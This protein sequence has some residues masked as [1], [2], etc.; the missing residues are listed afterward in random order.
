MNELRSSTNPFLADIRTRTR[1][2]EK[3]FKN[4]HLHDCFG[5]QEGYR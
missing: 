5:V 4:K 3:L 2:F 1:L